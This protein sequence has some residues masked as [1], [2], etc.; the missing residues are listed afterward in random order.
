MQAE[1]IQRVGNMS[2]DEKIREAYLLVSAYMR[3]EDI[4]KAREA[5]ERWAEV[6]KGVGNDD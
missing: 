2:R 5:L 3:A 4:A 1:I 6:V